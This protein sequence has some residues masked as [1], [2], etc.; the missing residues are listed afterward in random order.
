MEMIHHDVLFNRRGKSCANDALR[1][2]AH[3]TGFVFAVGGTMVRTLP[4]IAPHNP[5]TRHPG[6]TYT[7]WHDV[8][9]AEPIPRLARHPAH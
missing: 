3:P 7:A 4:F 5:H 1:T 9:N 2:S 6:N 8:T